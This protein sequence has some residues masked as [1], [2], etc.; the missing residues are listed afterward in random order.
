MDEVLES[1]CIF[2]INYF[3][4]VF[5]ISGNILKKRLLFVKVESNILV[6]MDFGYYG[7][8]LLWQQQ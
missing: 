5:L 3:G 8:W 1:S 2:H 6:T 4:Q 7:L